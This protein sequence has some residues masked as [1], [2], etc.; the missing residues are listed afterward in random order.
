MGPK[1]ASGITF[2]ECQYLSYIVNVNFA[3]VIEKFV[4][5]LL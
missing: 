1:Y 4:I 2:T 5:D 3:R